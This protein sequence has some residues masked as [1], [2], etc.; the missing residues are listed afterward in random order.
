MFTYD[1]YETITTS[2]MLA[3]E[4]IQH[5]V[6]CHDDDARNRFID[7]G[8]VKEDCIIATGQP[9]GLAYNRNVALEMMEDGEWALFLVDD[10]KSVT[11][12]DTYDEEPGEELP[13]TTANQSSYGPRFK[14]SLTLRRFIER[15]EATAR[16]GEVMGAALVGFCGIDNPLYRRKKWKMN[17]LADGRAWVVRK[18]HLQFDSNVQLIDDVAWC[19]LN[20]REFGAVVV[21]DWVLPDCRRYTAG[22]FGSKEE[23]M[24]QKVREARYLVETYPDYIAYKAKAGWPEGSHVV[25]R[26]RHKRRVSAD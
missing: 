5:I 3:S 24:E 17:V 9:R 13:I 19:A 11:E 2:P 6:L 23:R 8:N 18:T 4:G 21:N 15:A 16:Y 14:Q 1:R 10:L 20:I 12:L 22:A 26:Q 25:L 7:A